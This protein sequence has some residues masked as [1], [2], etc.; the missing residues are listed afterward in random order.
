MEP[1]IKLKDILRMLRRRALMIVTIVVVF[2]GVAFLLAYFIPPTYVARAKILIESQ[3]I[4][5]QLASSTVT[6]STNE[7]LELIKQRLMTRGNLLTL[8]ERL[9]LYAERPDLTKSQK[10]ELMRESTRLETIEVDGRGREGRIVSAF[11]LSYSDSDPKRAAQIT[12]EFVTMVLEQNIKARS[13]RAAMTHDFFKDEV[14]Q[15]EKELLRAE[16]EIAD[17]QNRNEMALPDSLNFRREELSNLRKLRYETRARVVKL[18]EERLTL[19]SAIDSGGYAAGVDTAMTPEERDLQILRSELSRARSVYAATHPTVRN[20][21]TRIAVMEKNLQAIDP[22]ALL[23][24]SRERAERV[25]AQI[26]RQIRAIDTELGLLEDQRKRSEAREAALETSIERTPE[27]AMSLNAMKRRYDELRIR[28]EEAVRKQSF[29][30]TGEKLEINRQAERFEVI[31]QAQV[32]ERPTS[33]N[34][35]AI[36]I[37]GFAGSLGFALSL[38]VLLGLVN[39]SIRTVGDMERKLEMRPLM[40]VP[41]ISTEAERR[42]ARLELYALAML[43]LVIVPISLYAVDQYY[44]PLE[45]LLDQFVERTN[46][47]SVIARIAEFLNR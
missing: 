43:V 3:Q 30:A 4:P 26:E 1:S 18:E 21:E 42:R 37:G 14:A 39:S 40:T 28:Y 19:Q 36:A 2:S 8:V 20:L 15:V 24:T 6:A 33:P 46:L 45:L 13:E 23:E 12:N 5:Q 47:R 9:D 34:R 10:V 7:R 31:E 16:T 22:S 25:R 44:L 27:V 29:A 35:P 41:Y 17:F 38:A 32:P 11:V